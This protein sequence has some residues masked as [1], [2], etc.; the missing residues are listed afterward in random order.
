MNVVHVPYL[1]PSRDHS[2]CMNAF[3][4]A[5]IYVLAYLAFSVDS[6]THGYTDRT[7][8]LSIGIVDSLASFPNTLGF[9]IGHASTAQD[10]PLIKGCLRDIR[11]HVLDR[12]YRDILFGWTVDYNST[13]PERDTLDVMMCSEPRTDFLG[14]ATQDI[15]LANCTPTEEILRAAESFTDTT[16]PVFIVYSGCMTDGSGDWDYVSKSYSEN[17]TTTLSG[18]VVDEYFKGIYDSGPSYGKPIFP[19]NFSP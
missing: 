7:L 4:D 6:P 11:Q 2:V 9:L 15:R 17:I 8:A 14:L 5:G 16:V 10:V 3:A 12:K 19:S 1:D 18:V 13:A